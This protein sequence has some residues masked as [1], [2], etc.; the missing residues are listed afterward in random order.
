[1]SVSHLTEWTMD[2]I[3]QRNAKLLIKHRNESILMFDYVTRTNTQNDAVT[4][5]N[6]KEVCNCGHSAAEKTG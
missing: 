5:G 6:R 4:K 1:M 3:L 2:T